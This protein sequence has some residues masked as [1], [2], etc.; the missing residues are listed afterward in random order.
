MSIRDNLN[1]NIEM[2]KRNMSSPYNFKGSTTFA[3][4]PTSGNAVNDTYYCTD[5]KCKYTWNGL[6]WFQSSLNESEYEETLAAMSE[7]V[8]AKHNEAMQEIAAVGSQLS[9]EIEELSNIGLYITTNENL[10][11]ELGG[12]SSDSGTVTEASNR[13]RTTEPI[14]AKLGSIIKLLDTNYY[15]GIWKYADKEGSQYIGYTALKPNDIEIKEDCYV[16]IVIRHKNDSEI[17]TT[18]VN[19]VIRAWLLK[20]DVKNFEKAYESLIINYDVLHFDEGCYIDASGDIGSIV[21]YTPIK[22]TDWVCKIIP[23][24]AGDTFTITS[25]GGNKSRSWCLVDSNNV[26]INRASANAQLNDYKVTATEDGSFIF[27]SSIT[28]LETH[29]PSINVLSYFYGNLFVN[30][31][32]KLR[33]D[34]DETKS[35]NE[36]NAN[37]I[38][39]IISTISTNFFVPPV[40]PTDNIVISDVPYDSSTALTLGEI[41]S[42]YDSLVTLFPNYITKTLLGYD[43]SGTYEIYR[44]DFTPESVRVTGDLTDVDY[45]AETMPIIFMDACI[46]GSEKP[47]ARALLNLMTL[48]SNSANDNGILGWLRMNMRFIIIPITNPYGYANNIRQNSNGVDL[49][50]NFG[51]LWAL[52]NSDPT[53]WQY[54]GESAFSENE[55]QYIDGIL[56]EYTDEILVYYSWHTHGDFTSYDNMTAFAQ[57]DYKANDMHRIGVQVTKMITQSGWGNHNLPVDSGY[58]GIVQFS[59]RMGTASIY[60]AGL[61]IPTASPECLYRFYDGES[62]ADYN[63][64]VNCL[65]VEYILFNIVCAIKEFLY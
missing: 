45:T 11:F 17:D 59:Q 41:Y 19:R 21:D 16:R 29:T 1:G 44:Y 42:G 31:I 46:H 64:D 63:A 4:L 10:S 9:L 61:G 51:R 43:T 3:A 54:R 39:N 58:I 34:I 47:C 28:H 65:N 27:N 18:I 33:E 49:N 23:C 24:K 5:K 48:I 56:Q 60:G 2:L 22:S 40:I 37:D 38:A 6:S 20:Y 13:I 52:G 55:T 7:D 8:Q 36:E 26:I 25:F 15:V 32:K 62:G 30:E 57:G 14:F 35:A 50:R 53:N 12:L